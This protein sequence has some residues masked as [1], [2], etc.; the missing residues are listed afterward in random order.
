MRVLVTG[1]RDW[2]HPPAVWHVLDWYE[3]VVA[4]SYDEVLTVVTGACPRGADRHAE[5]WCMFPSSHYSNVSRIHEPHPAGWGLLGRRAGFARN[6]E[7]VHLGAD[8][9]L[10]FIRNHSPGAT[11]CANLAGAHGI[12]VRIFREDADGNYLGEDR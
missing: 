5:N 12:P 8:V 9:C 2:A 3:R 4:N 1:S 11:N 7:M 10:A 6:A